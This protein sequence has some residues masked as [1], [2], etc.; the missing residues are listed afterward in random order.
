MKIPILILH[1]WGR[2]SSS[3]K[4]LKHLLEKDGYTVY[5][6]DLPGFG[7]EPLIT[8]N[9]Y[10]DDYVEFVAYFMKKH[11]LSYVNIIGHSFGGRVALKFAWKYPEKVSKLFLTGVP[12][13]RNTSFVKRTAFVI[14]VVSGS[15]LKKLPL[16]LQGFM[17]R[18]VY[19][20]L[21]EWDY[22][23]AGGLKEVFKNIINEDLV[24]YAQKITTP[25]Y[26]LWGSND[27]ITPVTD[28]EKITKIMPQ[29]HSIII[30]DSTHK[31]PYE[32][33]EG[34]IKSFKAY[35]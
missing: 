16:S 24:A 18:S 29:A 2:N 21:G 13:I 35:L 25:T 33:P 11:T 8:A 34:F 1:G 28:V 4:D 6:P 9:M 31:L 5:I 30:P 14:S 7:S 19:F 3:Y 27:W 32:N 22:Y 12:I 23:N 26:L 10:L 20:L 15:V 17:R